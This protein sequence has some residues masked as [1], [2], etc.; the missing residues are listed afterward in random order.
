MTKEQYLVMIA[1]QVKTRRNAI[2]TIAEMTKTVYAESDVT[3]Q[4]NIAAN[5]YNM[6]RTLRAE[7]KKAYPTQCTCTSTNHKEEAKS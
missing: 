7:M 2:E 6:T 1:Q 5:A 3:A 4:A